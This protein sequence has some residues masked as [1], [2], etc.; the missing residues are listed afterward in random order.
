MAWRGPIK[1]ITNPVPD[2]LNR[3]VETPAMIKSGNR[4][5]QVRRD[6]DKVKDFSVSLTD[7]DTTIFQYLDNVI[8]LQ[9]TDNGQLVKVP[10]NYASPERWKAIRKDGY[11]RDKNGKIQTPALAFRRTT[12]QRNDTLITLNRYL[13]YPVVKLY[14]EKNKYDRFSIMNGFSPVKEIYSV[15]EP[16]H[17][18]INYDFIVWTDYVEQLNDLVGTLNFSTED[19]WGD[20]VRFKFRTSISDF[21]FETTTESDKDRI[22]KSTFSMMVYAYLLP[23]KFE[24]Y[25]ATTQKA[26]TPRKVVFNVGANYPGQSSTPESFSVPTP[27]PPII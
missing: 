13:Q 24:N 21:A 12:M 22:V 18:I 4:A 1:P 20:K 3:L 27:P 14:S 11:M 6:K 19:Y 16:D 17:V 15:T 23:N 26:F 2:R 8:N 25:K 10:I 9:V 7:I 5:E